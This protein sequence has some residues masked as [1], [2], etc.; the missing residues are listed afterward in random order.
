MNTS[1]MEQA[2]ASKINA[3]VNQPGFGSKLAV[4]LLPFS[5]VEFTGPNALFAWGRLLGYSVLAYY[6]FN[7]MRPASY[8]FM[9]CAG[10]SLATSLSSTL[11]HKVN[12][13][14]S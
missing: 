3:T 14:K 10:L 2:A 13:E 11:F 12:K 8:V 7:K 1:T 9:G 5:P 4:G 6:T